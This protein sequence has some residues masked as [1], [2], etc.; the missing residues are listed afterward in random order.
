MPD[1]SIESKRLAAGGGDGRARADSLRE[2]QA[3]SEK[4]T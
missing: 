1:S 4:R 2:E 3:V